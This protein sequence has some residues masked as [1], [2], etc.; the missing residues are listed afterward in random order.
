[1]KEFGDMV[2]ENVKG[3][4]A[5]SCARIAAGKGR[6]AIGGFGQ[7]IRK[8]AIAIGLCDLAGCKRE[9]VRVRI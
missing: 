7:C 2:R 8:G 6:G 3:L 5:Y 4:Q 1:M 9:P